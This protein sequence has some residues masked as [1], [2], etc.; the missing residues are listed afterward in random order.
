MTV[1]RVPS[2]QAVLLDDT[3]LAVDLR[4]EDLDAIDE[5]VADGVFDSRES[6]LAFFLDAGLGSIHHSVE[7]STDR[8]STA[9]DEIG[10]ERSE[11][12]PTSVD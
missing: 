9:G 1:C 2:A 5:M 10:E 11:L 4:D 6:A 8:G 7:T 3:P 12:G